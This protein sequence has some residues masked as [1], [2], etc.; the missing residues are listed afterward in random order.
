[1][2]NPADHFARIWPIVGADLTDKRVALIGWPHG[3][4]LVDYLAASGVRRWQWINIPSDSEA[5]LRG[6]LAARHGA[7]LSP[8]AANC[9]SPTWGFQLDR[10]CPDLVIIAKS[11]SEARIVAQAAIQAQ[12][13]LLWVQPPTTCHPCRLITFFPGDVPSL[14]DSAPVETTAG[15]DI[16]FWR[17]QTAIPLCAG[18]ARAMLLRETPYARQDLAD[19]WASGVRVANLAGPG[20]PFEVVWSASIESLVEE[21]VFTTPPAQRGRLLIAGLGSL[22][23]VAA[24]HLIDHAAGFVIADPDRVDVYNPVRQAYPVAAIGRPKAAALRDQLLVLGAD[25][26]VALPQAL[27]DER[28]IETIIAKYRI[29]AALVVTGT[30]AD[31]AIAR[32]L[33]HGDIPHVGGRCYPRARYWEAILVD[34]RRGPSLADLRGHLYLGP[35]PPP[36]PEQQAAYSDAGALEAEPATLIESGW[37]AVWLARLTAQFLTPPGL[38]E[39]WFLELLA[40]AT[41]CLVG[42]VGTEPTAVGPAYRINQPGQIRAWSRTNIRVGSTL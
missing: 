16:S 11:G 19:L 32:A 4:V 3:E 36:T 18:L 35:T 26:V 12:V 17:W 10:T 13:P 22:G 9:F 31:F 25:E 14:L 1:M 40:A 5:R 6:E 15:D 42:G 24:V 20:D 30:A 28:Q 8:D 23:S 38:R 39:R 27:T 2:R 21:P 7:A 37:A 34:G 29:T 33:R 41:T